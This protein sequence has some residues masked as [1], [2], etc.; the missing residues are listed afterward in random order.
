MHL[1]N[2]LHRWHIQNHNSNPYKNIN[3]DS[4]WTK[5]T[6]SSKCTTQRSIVTQVP[7]ST[8]KQLWH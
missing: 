2:V 6:P 3:N 8:H 5:I 7:L 1:L 4:Q